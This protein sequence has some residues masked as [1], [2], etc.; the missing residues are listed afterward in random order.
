MIQPTPELLAAV[1]LAKAQ[2]LIRVNQLASCRVCGQDQ[3]RFED[4]VQQLNQLIKDLEAHH[5]TDQEL[6]PG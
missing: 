3:Q 1:R 4:A 5:A 2:C 6:P